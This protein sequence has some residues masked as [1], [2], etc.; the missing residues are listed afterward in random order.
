MG[1]SSLCLSSKKRLS[2]ET[3]IIIFSSSSSP[4]VLELIVLH[5]VSGCR[6]LFFAHAGDNCL[7]SGSGK[8]VAGFLGLSNF[9]WAVNPGSHKFSGYKLRFLSHNFSNVGP[10]SFCDVVCGVR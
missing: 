9:P 2:D 8:V 4:L 5:I 3:L 1:S 7:Q 6:S 10:Y